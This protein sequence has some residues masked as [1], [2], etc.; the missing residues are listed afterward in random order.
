MGN[1]ATGSGGASGTDVTSGSEL[2]EP[3]SI[4]HNGPKQDRSR[5]TRSALL[6]AAVDS[7]AESGWAASTVSVIA[8]RAGVSRGAAQHHFPT[9]EDLFIAAV[10]HV[11]SER[12]AYLKSLIE[13]PGATLTTEQVVQTVVEL[14]SGP[15]FRAALALWTASASEPHLRERVVPL[16]TRIGREVHYVTVQLLDAD[17]SK[18]G[19]KESIQATLDLARGLG[20]SNLL[21]DD[22]QR[23]G[24]IIKQWAKMLESTL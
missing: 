20:L 23:R 12:A 19:V 24:P 10:E 3:E 11:A 22:H 8:E 13:A 4:E 1:E 15:L 2:S 16:E 18:P 9:R 5:A 14:Y 21:T 17:E 7:L 6:N